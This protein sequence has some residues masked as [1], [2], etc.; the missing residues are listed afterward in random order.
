MTQQEVK[1]SNVNLTQ[2]EVNDSFIYHKWYEKNDSNKYTISV[3]YKD[4][5]T[6]GFGNL[7]VSDNIDDYIPFMQYI[8][9][10]CLNENGYLKI[11]TKMSKVNDLSR[12]DFIR[13]VED[14]CKEFNLKLVALPSKKYSWIEIEKFLG[15]D[16]K[17]E[18][19]EKDET[20]LYF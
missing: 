4:M 20:I 17:F 19:N 10:Y 11:F 7:F 14:L 15:D 13:L 3:E 12:N 1:D 16:L 9:F 18:Y 2:E 6:W 8:K 5:I